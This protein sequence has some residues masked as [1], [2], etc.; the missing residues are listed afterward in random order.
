[1]H[2]RR[3]A[4][5]T[6]STVR[7][8]IALSL[9]AVALASIVAIAFA[10]KG[11]S[12]A[13]PVPSVASTIAVAS[14][15]P[16]VDER[17]TFRLAGSVRGDDGSTLGGALI[18]DHP[19]FDGSTTCGRSAQDGSFAIRVPAGYHKLEI[20]PP[21]DSAYLTAWYEE[22]DR[23]RD[24]TLL[25]L[26]SADRAGLVIRLTSGRRVNGTLVGPGGAPVAD[27]QA[28]ADP[29]DRPGEW[30]CG[31]SDARGRY[32][33]AVADGAY[34]L[35][36]VP[37]EATRLVPRWWRSGDQVLAADPLV[38]HR[39]LSGIDISFVEGNLISGKVTSTSGKAVE[40]A[41]VCVDTR[42]PTGRICRST[43]K[44]GEYSVA[45][46]RGTFVVQFV[47]SPAARVVNEW[48]GGT[49]D[50]LAARDLVVEGDV[51]LDASLRSGKLL[52]GAVRSVDGAPL[53]SA[54][55][56]VYD[57]EGGTFVAG[58]P[59]GGS[60]DYAVVIPTGRFWIEAYPPF[61][62]PYLSAYYGGEARR[63]I[64][65]RERDNDA[66]ADVALEP[67]R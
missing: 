3:R 9:G 66:V 39:D 25:D 31:R 13:Q 41:L 47:A 42:F 44:Q 30:A 60:G 62:Q 20:V 64:E 51:R 16:S 63:I 56:N 29:Y 24:A 28:C 33:L 45:V 52:W 6:V 26:R 53:E 21:A 34:L 49:A 17:N 2:S 36:F 7:A 58:G 27:A 50:P 18:C 67:V 55:V 54:F 43:N 57:A 1:M 8:R 10:A 22:R 19:A 61:G 59:T 14:S 4:R 37:P 32:S 5:R 11:G 65:V 15:L 38:V 46:R 35:F 23:S 12:P 48:Y 40:H